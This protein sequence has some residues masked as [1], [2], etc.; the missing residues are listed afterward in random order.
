MRFRIIQKIIFNRGQVLY[1][2][3]H[4][5]NML[6]LPV[7]FKSKTGELRPSFRVPRHGLKGNKIGIISV[8]MIQTMIFKGAP[9]LV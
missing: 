7:F 1:L 2:R 6:P 5:M 9:T 4:T 3:Q 8:A